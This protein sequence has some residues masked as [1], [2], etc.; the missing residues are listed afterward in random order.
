MANA[1]IRDWPAAPSALS[2]EER[3]Q[4]ERQVHRHRVAHSLSARCRA[5]L[6]R[7]D[8]RSSRLVA[9]EL[10]IHEHTVGK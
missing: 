5:I 4:L 2:A 9:A 6:R 3:A 1:G 10:G 7:A 8:G